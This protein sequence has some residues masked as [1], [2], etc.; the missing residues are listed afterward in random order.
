[1]NNHSRAM[2]AAFLIVWLSASAFALAPRV[3]MQGI[4]EIRA[5][6]GGIGALPSECFD[7]D[8]GL[9][10]A[11]RGSY[12]KNGTIFSDECPVEGGKLLIET[13]C[14]GDCSCQRII[15]AC[16]FTSTCNTGKCGYRVRYNDSDNDRDWAYEFNIFRKGTVTSGSVSHTDECSG[17]KVL[18]YGAYGGGKEVKCPEGMH[19]DDGKCIGAAIAC[20][21]LVQGRNRD[22]NNRYNI[23]FVGTDYHELYAEHDEAVDV[24]K[25]D[26]IKALGINNSA[27]GLF[28]IEP[29]KSNITKFNFWYVDRFVDAMEFEGAVG[30]SPSPSEGERRREA[31]LSQ[32]GAASICNLNNKIIISLDALH[33]WNANGG[34]LINFAAYREQIADAPERVERCV[35]EINACYNSILR[36]TDAKGSP[37]T[38]SDGDRCITWSDLKYPRWGS[39][40]QS[41]AVRF[42]VCPVYALD[43]VDDYCQYNSM[44][45][46]GLAHE[47]AHFLGFADEAYAMEDDEVGEPLSAAFPSVNC[48]IAGSAEECRA[49]APW[50]HLIGNGCGV[51]STEDCTPDNPDFNKEVTC[52]PG[53]IGGKRS[54]RSIR[55]SLM[56]YGT[57]LSGLESLYKPLSFG[58]W[59]EWYIT[60]KLK[61]NLEVKPPFAT[62]SLR[63]EPRVSGLRRFFS[64][65]F[66]R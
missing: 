37:I 46:E 3:P 21:G 31:E 18:E 34:D 57:G 24:F 33:G 53:C 6:A 1:M 22:Y 28:S 19:C 52:F 50:K 42:K 40:C 14:T 17:G 9:N 27:L 55:Y 43:E 49:K 45:G 48:F 15:E 61:A 41:H 47:M 39:I 64:G 5:G 29:F 59:N 51:N 63:E 10:F 44:L 38:N 8:N 56:P 2:A 62:L 60:Q 23:V 13:L 26:A 30:G 65:I 54:Y 66:R 7:T 20:N 4:Q 32:R 16:P 25:G 58:E 11:A 12:L 36:E 35:L